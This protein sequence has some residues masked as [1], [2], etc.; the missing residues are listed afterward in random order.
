MYNIAQNQSFFTK[1]GV[2]KKVTSFLYGRRS[3]YEKT[4]E[5][6]NQKFTKEFIRCDL[7]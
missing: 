3:N 1:K 7:N 6:S 5:T 4:K 2:T